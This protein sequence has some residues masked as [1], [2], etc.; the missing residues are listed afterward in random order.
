MELTRNPTLSKEAKIRVLG[1]VEGTWETRRRRFF[2][3]ECAYALGTVRVG[4]TQVP[5]T[6]MGSENRLMALDK[7]ANALLPCALKCTEP[8]RVSFLSFAYPRYMTERLQQ[9]F[10]TAPAKDSVAQAAQAQRNPL[11]IQQQRALVF[12]NQE[13]VKAGLP[14]EKTGVPP[15][16]SKEPWYLM[17]RRMQRH[18]VLR[19]LGPLVALT[20][21]V[22][23]IVL[24]YP[25]T[26]CTKLL[27]AGSV[28]GVDVMVLTLIA[29]STGFLANLAWARHKGMQILRSTGNA[30]L[31]E[32]APAQ[33]MG[34]ASSYVLAVLSLIAALM[35]LGIRMFCR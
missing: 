5:L 10:S 19:G 15:D 11:S 7:V 13:R 32:L 27:T 35:L 29:A 21:L 33:A 28:R 22:F 26:I 14:P 3:V 1:N 4:E 30:H 2:E 24:M 16:I 6:W 18:L 12:L 25:Q 23:A 9:L 17:V 8:D 20:A 31:V 34:T